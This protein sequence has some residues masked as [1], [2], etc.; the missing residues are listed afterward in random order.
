[1]KLDELDPERI[2]RLSLEFQKT[3]F[4]Q[5]LMAALKQMHYGLHQEA[6]NATGIEAKALKVERA[7]GVREVID[8]VTMPAMLFNF[9]READAAEEDDDSEE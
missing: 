7:A 5:Y 4:G 3:E 1:M 8:A 2:G 9:L 6:E